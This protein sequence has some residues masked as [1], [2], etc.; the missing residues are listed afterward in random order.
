MPSLIGYRKF[1]I[2]LVALI[3]GVGL[4]AFGRMDGSQFVTL[5]ASVFAIFGTA[6]VA[7]K[8][9]PGGPNGG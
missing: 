6:N 9:N 4:C 5:A 2:A 7:A 3:S 1:T 8:R